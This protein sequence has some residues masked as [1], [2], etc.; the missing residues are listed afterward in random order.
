MSVAFNV[1]TELA[2]TSTSWV[3]LVGCIVPNN[4]LTKGHNRKQRVVSMIG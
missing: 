4:K 2:G 3:E 1:L